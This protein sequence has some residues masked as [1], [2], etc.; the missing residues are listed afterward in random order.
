MPILKYQT[1]K[2]SVF[3]AYYLEHLENGF[4][5]AMIVGVPQAIQIMK[6]FLI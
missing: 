4:P 5:A 6:V 2:K 3:A 1:F